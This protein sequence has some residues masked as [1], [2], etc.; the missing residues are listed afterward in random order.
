MFNEI[1]SFDLHDLKF[2]NVLTGETTTQSN[3][4]SVLSGG[5]LTL[6][7]FSKA[8]VIEFVFKE[9]VTITGLEGEKQGFIKAYPNPFQQEINVDIMSAVGGEAQLFFCSS[10]GKELAQKSISIKA[11][12]EQKMVWDM[13]NQKLNTGTY[14]L[15]LQI[16]QQQWTQKLLKSS[17]F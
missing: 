3:F 8:I 12:Q 2:W 6:P 11:N 5:L 4:N 1:T 13:G 15:K 9:K 7:I 16:G 14:I 17:N 10:E